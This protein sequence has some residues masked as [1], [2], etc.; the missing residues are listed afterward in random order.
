MPTLLWPLLCLL[1]ACVPALYLRTSPGEGATAR[2]GEEVLALPARVPLD[3]V[4]VIRVE[5]EGCAPAVLVV[6]PPVRG[7]HPLPAVDGAA[8]AGGGRGITLLLQC[9]AP[10]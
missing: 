10:E 7:V 1:P 9:E 3:R 5:R 6:G 8:L 4:R 2:T